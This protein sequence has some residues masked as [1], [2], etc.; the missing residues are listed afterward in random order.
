MIGH[1]AEG[2]KGL[3]VVFRTHINALCNAL[4]SQMYGD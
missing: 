4:L 1:Y 3:M 2:V